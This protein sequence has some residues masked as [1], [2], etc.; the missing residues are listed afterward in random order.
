[1]RRRWADMTTLAALTL[2]L[3]GA[4]WGFG[5][6]HSLGQNA[7]HEKITRL[8]L[9]CGRNA[10]PC[11]QPASLDELAGK[12]GTLGAVGA[13]DVGNLTFQHKAHCDGGDF[14]D[15]PGYPQTAAQA[16]AALEACRAWMRSELDAAARDAGALLDRNGAVRPGE[17]KLGCRF[18][19]MLQGGAKCRVLADFGTSLHAAQDFYAHS[20]WVDLPASGPVS[21]EN[22]PGLGH[23]APAPWLDWRT[24]TA[25]PKG[26]I[27]DCFTALPEKAFCNYAKTSRVK[28]AF[29]NKDD[30]AIDLDSGRIGAGTTP[31]GAVNA[32]FARAVRA[33]EGETQVKWATLVEALRLRYGREKGDRMVCV[34]AMDDP[35]KVCA[36][37]TR[38]ARDPRATGASRAG[39]R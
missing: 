6:T 37:K 13:P 4:A 15:V 11:F 1:M 35:V 31:R 30:G 20:N 34:I 17:I 36:A 33:A 24:N 8:A 32:N 18:T 38:A 12:A 3:A 29:I 22:P 25:F 23:D 5:T 2:A 14:R 9:A 10:A 7:E 39:G 28:H 19:G 21:P 16:R 26:L 27:S